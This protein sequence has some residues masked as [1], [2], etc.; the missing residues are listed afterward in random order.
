MDSSTRRAGSRP[1]APPWGWRH[2]WAVLGVVLLVLWSPF[3]IS[4][5]LV[6]PGWVTFPA[7]AVWLT[8]LGLAGWWFRSHPLRTLAVGAGSIA[9]WLAAVYLFDT[10]LGWTA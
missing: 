9:L 2:L 3:Y 7:V 8:L 10:L 1:A 6:A 4:I 5:G